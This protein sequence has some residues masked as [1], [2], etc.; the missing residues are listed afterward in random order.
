MY[1]TRQSSL[2]IRFALLL[3]FLGGTFGVSSPGQAL[4]APQSDTCEPGTGW[5]WTRGPSRPDV[6]QKAELAL[7]K[8]GIESVVVATDYGEKD[9]CGN[10]EL[11]G[12][13]FTVTLKNNSNLKLS[14]EVQSEIADRIRAALLP[15]GEPQLGN[16]RIDFGSGVAKSYTDSA[17][18]QNPAASLAVTSDSSSTASASLNKKVFL[19]VYDPTLI[20]GQDLN[21]YMGWPAYMSLV[22]GVISSFQTASQGQL[23]YTIAQQV[24]AN[25]WPVKIDGFRYTETTYFQVWQGQT[26]AHNPDEVNYDLILDQFDICGKLNRGEI[27]ELWMFGAPYFGFYES[28]LVGP[29]AYV[30]NSPPLTQTHGCNKLLPI[31]GLSYERGVGDAVHSFGHRVEAT[32]TRVYGSWEENRTAHNWDRFGLVKVQSPDYNYSGC[33]S[34]H[35]PLNAQIAYEYDNPN[36]TSTNCED[37]RNYPNLSD[38]QSVLQ[39]VNCTAW[40]CDQLGYMVYWFNHLPS[41]AGCGP[42][43]MENNWWLYF[44]DPSAALAPSQNCSPPP[45]PTITNWRGEYWNNNALIGSPVVCRDDPGINFDWGSA[46]P[47][48][49]LPAD[50][51]SAR[52]TR[53]VNFPGGIYRFY[54]FNDDGARLY[55]DDVLKIDVWGTCCAWNQ[56]DVTLPAGDHSI[57]MEMFENLGGATAKLS[58]EQ[59]GQLPTSTPTS[60]PTRTPTSTFTPTPTLNPNRSMNPLYLSFSSGQ[61]IGG[62]SSSDEDILKFDGT[63]WSLLFDGSDVGVGSPDLFAFSF[64][65]A[66]SILMSFTVS[67]TVNGITATPQDI[68]RFDAT[69]LG[70]TTAGTFSLYFDGSDVGFEDTTNEKID[71]LSLL[72][73]GRL[74]ISSTGNPVVAGVS[75]AKD[76]DVLAFTPTSLGNVT[77]GTWAMYFDGSDVGLAE[78]SGEDVDALDV[79]GGNIYLSTHDIFSVNGLAGADEDVFICVATSLGDITACNYSSTLY[80]DG[81]TWGLDAN[82]VDAFSFL[83]SGPVP[84]ITPTATQT[85]TGTPTGTPTATNTPTRTPTATQTPTGAIPPTP[86]YT[87][88][89]TFTSTP[90]S[91]STPTAASGNTFTFT[92]IADA[93]VNSG[94]ATTNYGTS[95]TLRADASPDLHSYLRFNVQGLNGNVTRAT[96]RIFANSA[97]TLGCNANSLSDNTW[98]ESTINYSNAPAVGSIIGSSTP[99]GAGVWITLDVTPYITGN[100]T[101]N[102]GL[103]TPSGTAISFASREA[104]VNAPQLIIETVP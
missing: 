50:Y 93:Y 8:E 68:L 4:P 46:G 15:V 32:M 69:S 49:S 10:F 13:D 84:T 57:R 90:T 104:G 53:T 30:Y 41:N 87:P 83:A 24:V 102:L 54:M 63:N 92:S 81:S 95:T 38:P 59:I 52:W 17:D 73:D 72:P 12:T 28:R 74:L 35:Y 70:S 1:L 78:T 96:L 71:S 75:S 23:Q 103:T 39:P 99:F 76:E 77:S 86:T 36:N 16:V 20:N 14:S 43:F 33:G 6:A 34:I 21:T 31:M 47:D 27:D 89:P 66:D 56:T 98:T 91:T 58:W 80:F 48:P 51:F 9:S 79:V 40:N 60:T 100:G 5:V 97:S 94:S 61:T 37:F 82:D 11:F 64:L 22:Q 65:D 62:V 67:V 26:P 2:I 29:G 3:A 101:Y 19:L 45:C 55:V 7:K 44:T 42:D 88:T 25:E 85:P 18:V